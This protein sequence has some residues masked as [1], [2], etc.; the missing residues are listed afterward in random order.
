MNNSG[1]TMHRFYGFIYMMLLFV[2]AI[3]FPV[4]AGQIRIVNSP[5]ENAIYLTAEDGRT[6]RLDVNADDDEDGID[7]ILEING[8]TYSC[9]PVSLPRRMTRWLPPAR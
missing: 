7:N 5:Q 2:L 9:R 4:L 1:D 3:D 8:F 6:L